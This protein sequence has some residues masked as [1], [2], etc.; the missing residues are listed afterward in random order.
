MSAGAGQYDFFVG[1][2]AHNLALSWVTQLSGNTHPF[3]VMHGAVQKPAYDSQL[4]FVSEFRGA[5]DVPDLGKTLTNAQAVDTDIALFIVEPVSGLV[6]M[7]KSFPSVGVERSVGVSL[8]P[9]GEIAIVGNFTGKINFSGV[10]VTGNTHPD[11]LTSESGK[12]GFIA[13]FDS[14]GEYLWSQSYGT[15]GDDQALSA[16]FDSAGSLY[17]TFRHQA[18]IDFGLG[19]VD[20]GMNV[21]TIVKFE[22]R[23]VP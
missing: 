16:V 15:A 14:K 20:E 7:A 19:P 4:V 21:G 13:I 18:G 11:L 5:L 22:R 8:G 10:A 3:P 12:D 6:S 1:R 9:D 2:I 23:G 17:V